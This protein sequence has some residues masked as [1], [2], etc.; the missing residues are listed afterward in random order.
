LEA[1]EALDVDPHELARPELGVR[2]EAPRRLGEQVAETVGPVPAKDPVD[3]ARVQP[4]LVPEPVLTI[5]ELQAEREHGPF[6]GIGRPA[7]GVVRPARSIGDVGRPPAPAV[8]R[9]TADPALP[10]GPA[11]PDPL[12]LGDDERPGPRT[13]TLALVQRSPSD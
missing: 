8:H 3:R 13:Q 10:G 7:R 1:A 11:H 5:L 12:G 6:E 4:E 9:P 2:P